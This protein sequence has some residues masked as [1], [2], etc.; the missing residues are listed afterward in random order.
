[1]DKSKS[2]VQAMQARIVSANYVASYRSLGNRK[3][4]DEPKKKGG[5]CFYCEGQYNRDGET[6]R[7]AACRK[8]KNDRS[9]GGS[10]SCEVEKK[11]S[12]KKS[13]PMREEIPANVALMQPIKKLR[14]RL[15]RKQEP[16]YGTTLTSEQ[17]QQDA[18]ELMTSL[19]SSPT[20][21]SSSSTMNDDENDIDECEQGYFPSHSVKLSEASARLKRPR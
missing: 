9:I 8:M 13:K 7:K 12:K 3:W 18:D 17:T 1:M 5:E 14:L 4:E 16:G 21:S 15:W 19:P 6:H 10:F 11:G 20:P 2:H